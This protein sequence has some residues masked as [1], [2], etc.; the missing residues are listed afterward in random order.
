MIRLILIALL[1]STGFT[2]PEDQIFKTN[3]TITVRD[4]AGNTVEK[5]QVVLFLKEEDY[6]KEVNPVVKGETDEKGVVKFK[7]LK[8]H[9][10]FVLA[11]KDDK[12]NSGGGEKTD[13]L[14]E[15]KVN[16]VTIIIQ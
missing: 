1:V 9:A 10:Y 8:P 16:K 4:E 3:L 7:G 11:R 6:T 2:R 5:A 14:E 15:G 13:A 12:D